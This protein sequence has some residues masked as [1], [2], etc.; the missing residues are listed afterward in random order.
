MKDNN[1]FSKKDKTTENLVLARRAGVTFYEIK[2]RFN[3]E[4]HKEH[5]EKI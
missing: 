4:V 3:R 1:S 5:E 2:K